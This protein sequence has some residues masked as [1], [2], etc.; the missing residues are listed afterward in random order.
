MRKILSKKFNSWN[1]NKKINTVVTGLNCCIAIILLVVFTSFYVT[2]YIRQANNLTKSQLSALATNYEY[3]L[4]SYNGLV[5]TLIIDNSVQEYLSEE[6]NSSNSIYLS[7]NAKNTLQ[8]AVNMY[9]SLNYIAIVSKDSSEILNKGNI[10]QISSRFANIYKDDYAKSIYCCS[11]GPL[12]MNYSDAYLGHGNKTINLYIP[13]YSTSVIHRQIGL[14]C[15]IFNDSL[16]QVLSNSDTVNINSQAPVMLIND[17]QIISS[18]SKNAPI[19]K[20]FSQMASLQGTSGDFVSQSNLYNYQKINKWNFY[21]VSQIPL[22]EMYR[23]CILVLLILTVLLILLTFVSLT[24]CKKIINRTYT[25]LERVVQAMNSVAEGKLD[26]RIKMNKVGSDFEKLTNGFNYMMDEMNTLMI[27]VKTEQQQMDQIRFNALQSQIQPH[28]L[29]N[30][31]DSIHWKAMA[32]GNHELSEFVKV[33]AQYY[34]ISLSKGKDII[35]LRQEIEHVR[36][37]L[38]IQNMR[39]DEVIYS[40]FDIEE[41][42]LNTLIPKITLQPLVENSIYHGIRI[43]DGKSGKIKIS[44]FRKDNDVYVEV[45][46]NGSGMTDNEI[47][48]MNRSIQRT[49]TEIGYGIRNVNRRLVLLFGSQYG[50]HYSRNESSGITV[51]VHL[52]GTVTLSSEEVL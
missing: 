31:L 50:L 47:E 33:L 24:V 8:N 2:S 20:R 7:F 51:T 12:R 5:E 42:C 21:L 23:N 9:P 34:R 52:P 19:G 48:K 30:A 3:I 44:A 13:V 36:N 17:T 46:D 49:D 28:F 40:D 45:E 10:T 35:S 16:F 11:E 39:F 14:L 37:Y 27:Q 25:P 29:Y 32:D 41:G 1:L 22:V 26:V 38:I 4:N 6:K 43:K 18:D 15:V